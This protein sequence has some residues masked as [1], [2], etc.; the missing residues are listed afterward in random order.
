MNPEAMKHKASLWDGDVGTSAHITD[1]YWEGDIT[2]LE[3]MEVADQIS[4]DWQTL[5]LE[6]DPAHPCHG[7]TYRLK[8]PQSGPSG[9]DDALRVSEAESDLAGQF[10][11]VHCCQNIDDPEGE[12]EDEQGRSY[13]QVFDAI[14]F[15]TEF[16]SFDDIARQCDENFGEGQWD[17]YQ[18]FLDDDLPEPIA[19]CGNTVSAGSV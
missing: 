12:L 19:C 16:I 11:W 13:H 17:E 5:D 14:M 1:V 15:C 7:R 8:R 18:L 9:E 2:Q 4:P 6:L 10:V 3:L